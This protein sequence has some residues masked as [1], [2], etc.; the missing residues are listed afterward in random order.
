VL[1]VEIR[2]VVSFEQWV[3]EV[4]ELIIY[5]HSTANGVAQFI[6]NHLGLDL[7]L[8]ETC[9]MSE[10]TQPLFLGSLGVV[11]CGV[12]FDRHHFG[13]VKGIVGWPLFGILHGLR[14]MFLQT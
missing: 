11:F 9:C 6:Q 2:K 13:E 8:N 1:L 5:L 4:A 7:L 3:T 14:L 10:L 12:L